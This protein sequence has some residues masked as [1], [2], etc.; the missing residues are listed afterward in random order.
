MPEQ[1]HCRYCGAVIDGDREACARHQDLADSERALYQFALCTREL[2]CQ[3]PADMHEPD[4]PVE[5]QM[6]ADYG[7]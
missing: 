5:A 6:K 2:G 3:A 4:C 1:R 7:F